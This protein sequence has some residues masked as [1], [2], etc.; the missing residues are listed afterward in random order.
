MQNTCCSCYINISIHVYSGRLVCLLC[1]D[2]LDEKSLIT[3]YETSEIIC[4]RCGNVVSDENGLVDQWE[5]ND[6]D[7]D[8]RHLSRPSNNLNNS[9]ILKSKLNK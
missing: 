5:L 1:N 6:E 7:E 8:F 3:D 9:L 4:S 2:K